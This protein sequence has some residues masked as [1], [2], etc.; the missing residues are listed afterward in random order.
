MP[1]FVSHCISDTR[2]QTLGRLDGRVQKYEFI[3]TRNCLTS[4]DF[5]YC[6]GGDRDSHR[7]QKLLILQMPPVMG[8]HFQA[9]SF[10]GEKATPRTKTALY[11]K[12]V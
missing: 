1:L 6:F 9:F 5:C 11:C 12:W 2:K 10:D 4:Y 8:Q 3:Y 7:R